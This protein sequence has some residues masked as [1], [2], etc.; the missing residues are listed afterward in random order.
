MKKIILLSVVIVLAATA[1]WAQADLIPGQTPAPDDLT[2]Q[3]MASLYNRLNSIDGLDD[4]VQVVSLEL[5]FEGG[6]RNDDGTY[7]FKSWGGEA[8]LSYLTQ[9]HKVH[10]LVMEHRDKRRTWRVEPWE[11]DFLRRY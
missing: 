2:Q 4:E 9:G 3:V 6:G 7:I 11:L 5:T 10:I 1:A 8:V